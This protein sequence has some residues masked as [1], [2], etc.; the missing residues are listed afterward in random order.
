MSAFAV[1]LF[2]AVAIA[3]V[4]AGSPAFAQCNP[5]FD[6]LCGETPGAGPDVGISPDG[7]SFEI[8]ADSETRPAPSVTIVFTDPDGVNP[9]SL[10][11]RLWNGGTAVPVTLTTLPTSDVYT[12]RLKGNVPLQNA[13]ESVL[14]AQLADSLGNVGSSR[15]TFR[16]TVIDPNV[17]IVTLDSH[18]NEYRDTTQGAFTLAYNA[19]SYTSG[20]VQRGVS[21][22]YNSAHARPTVPVHVDAKIDY[23]AFDRVIALSL[24]MQQWTADGSPGTQVGR[25]AYYQ[26]GA[27]KQRLAW[28]ID[29]NSATGAFRYAAVVRSQFADGGVTEKRQFVR[30]LLINQKNSRYGVGWSVAG[31]QRVHAAQFDSGVVVNEGNGIARFF[32]N[33]AC[34]STECSYVTPAG[35]FSRLVKNLVSSAYIRTFPDGSTITYSLGGL[36]THVTDRFGN[37]TTFEWQQTQDAA[38][39]WVVSRIVDPFGHASTFAYTADGYL[40]AI[41]SA[42]RTT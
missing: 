5:S 30:L 39:E 19:G 9:D 25:E 23:R 10:Q 42:G 35:D 22:V 13:G 4:L 24:R 20:G 31:V 40:Q 3:G 7:G 36:M 26:R 15:V 32:A 6:P 28:S 12:L 17:P 41:T 11:L 34:T 16:V 21:L 27:F 18:H 8:D 14:V 38:K 29:S 2:I 37:A 33:A 1:R